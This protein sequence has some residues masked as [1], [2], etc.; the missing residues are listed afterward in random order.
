VKT[1][2]NEEA[3]AAYLRGTA[4]ILPQV[5]VSGDAA[6][7]R[8][9]LTH[10]LFHEYMYYNPHLRG[11][12]YGIIGFQ[13]CNEIAL[14][15]WLTDHR[16]TSPNPEPWDF[17]V[18]VDSG[19]ERVPCLLVFYSKSTNYT[20]GQLFDYLE[21]RLLVL[22]ERQD[23]YHRVARLPVCLG[24]LTRPSAL[25]RSWTITN[26]SDG[27]PATSSTRRDP[28]RELRVGGGQEQRRCFAARALLAKTNNQW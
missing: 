19:G 1:T 26:R 5:M 27:T 20:G 13:L 23:G 14:P 18:R 6:Q 9:V 3:N 11:V 28:G 4:I 10:E 25:G 17:F 2:G 22:E 15:Q 21:F 24:C 8:R 7:L 16:I 12:L